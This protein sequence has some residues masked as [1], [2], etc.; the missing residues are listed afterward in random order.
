MEWIGKMSELSGKTAVVTGAASGIGEACAK[1]LA[2]A[3]ANVVLCDKAA[4][5][6]NTVAHEIG[7]R[8]FPLLVDLTRAEEVSSILD[9]VVERFGCLDILLANAG[10]YVGGD[11]VDGDPDEWDRLIDLNVKSVLRLVH[12]VVPH[13]SANGSGDIIVTSSISGHV[14]I[15]QEPIYSASK[16]AVTSFVHNLRR[17]VAPQGLRVGNV[18]PGIVITPL[19]D[20]WTPENR[21]NLLEG[22]GGLEPE[23]VADAVVY[24]ATRPSRVTIRDMV[25]VPQNQ[26]I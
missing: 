3:G 20:S 8:A 7:P 19:L 2:N 1:A 4:D 9:K 25:V 15:P 21:R 23:D 14:D 22:K 26:D 24:M 13:M 11:V 6:L 12:L 16:H 17:Q 10:L 5:R 18:A